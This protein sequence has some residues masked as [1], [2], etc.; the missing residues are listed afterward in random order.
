MR[1]ED[2]MRSVHYTCDGCGETLKRPGQ[3]D[4]GE[5][6]C[7][8]VRLCLVSQATEYLAVDLCPPCLKR[9]VDALNLRGPWRDRPIG[10]DR[11]TY[12]E[13]IDELS[14]YNPIR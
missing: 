14:P 7:P 9:A 11:R 2:A 5:G 4:R 13:V 12:G 1:H 3:K 6:D 8:D 10:P